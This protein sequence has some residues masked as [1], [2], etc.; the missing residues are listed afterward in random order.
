MLCNTHYNFVLKEIGGCRL[1]LKPVI[2]GTDFLSGHARD[3]S[4][5]NV[6]VNNI[7]M[8]HDHVRTPGIISSNNVLQL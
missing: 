2:V 6:N 8:P 1:E 4:L 5:Y 7:F 3:G